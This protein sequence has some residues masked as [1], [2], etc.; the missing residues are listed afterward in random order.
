MWRK[1]IPIGYGAEASQGVG[2]FYVD[3]SEVIRFANAP[4][5]AGPKDSPLSSSGGQFKLNEEKTKATLG[6]IG[7][8]ESE[9]EKKHGRYGAL[10]NKITLRVSLQ[11]SHKVIAAEN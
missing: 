5:V 4:N 1:A 6:A 9:F 3:D 11:G 7:R 2:S 10:S 8:A